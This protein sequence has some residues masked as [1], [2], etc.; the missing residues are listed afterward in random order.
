MSC[1]PHIQALSFTK[2]IQYRLQQNK[3]D[4]GQAQHNIL[5]QSA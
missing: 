2:P 3:I 4:Q 1:K 5:E